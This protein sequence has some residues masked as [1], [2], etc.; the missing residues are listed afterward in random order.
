MRPSA[1]DQHTPERTAMI[2]S[3]SVLDRS[4]SELLASTAR[5]EAAVGRPRAKAPVG[6]SEGWS[7]FVVERNDTVLGGFTQVDAG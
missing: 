3:G 7:A 4:Q 1:S 5:A 6:H 2:Q